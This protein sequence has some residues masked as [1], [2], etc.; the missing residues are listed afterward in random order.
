VSVPTGR[1]EEIAEAAKALADA[2]V[3]V[4][5]IR[6]DPDAHDDERYALADELDDAMAALDKVLWRPPLPGAK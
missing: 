3:A 1:L 5:E 4:L 6:D 2:A